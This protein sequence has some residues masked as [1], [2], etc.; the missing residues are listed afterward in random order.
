M[1]IKARALYMFLVMPAM[2]DCVVTSAELMIQPIKY[3]IKNECLIAVEEE[4]LLR[5]DRAIVLEC[6][7]NKLQEQ[8]HSS[9]H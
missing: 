6:S 3:W 8:Q 4:I 9:I 1:M 7:V 2:V 5:A